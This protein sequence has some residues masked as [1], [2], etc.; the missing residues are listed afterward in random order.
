M[1]TTK[2]EDDKNERRPKWKTTKMVRCPLS[3]IIS[4]ETTCPSSV[5]RNKSIVPLRDQSL[6]TT[7]WSL[8][9][10]PTSYRILFV[11]FFLLILSS[12]FSTLVLINSSLFISGFTEFGILDLMDLLKKR[13]CAL[14]LKL[15]HLWQRWSRPVNFC[16]S[17][18]RLPQTVLYRLH[19]PLC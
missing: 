3:V 6:V 15:Y 14:H 19:S 9:L 17:R 16:E 10:C 1:K 12:C 5:V 13:S 7:F 8:T 11:L 18:W 2:M 4:Y